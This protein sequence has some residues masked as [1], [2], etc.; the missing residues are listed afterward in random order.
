METNVILFFSSVGMVMFLAIGGV[1]GWIYKETV[2]ASIYA[3]S[4]GITHPEMLDQDGY[5]INEELYSV[6]F[7]DSELDDEDDY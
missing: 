6:R 4:G 3:K 5:L 7:I 1:V 2:D